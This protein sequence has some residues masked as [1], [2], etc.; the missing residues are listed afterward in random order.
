MGENTDEDHYRIQIS[1]V[2]LHEIMVVLV[3]FALKLVVE[4]DVGAASCSM[5]GRCWYLTVSF[6]R[7]EK[8]GKGRDHKTERRR[9]GVDWTYALELMVGSLI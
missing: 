6:P 4:L 9:E 2:F 7:T 8:Q 1:L 5:E 3:G